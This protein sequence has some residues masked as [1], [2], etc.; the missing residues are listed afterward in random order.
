MTMPSIDTCKAYTQHSAS[1]DEISCIR[2][3]S[4]RHGISAC[5]STRRVK[6]LAV[7]A[8]I[9]PHST[10]LTSHA[11]DPVR[12]LAWS[13]ARKKNLALLMLRSTNWKFASVLLCCSVTNLLLRLLIENSIWFSRDALKKDKT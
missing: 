9:M 3:A 8:W 2:A 7:P 6:L 13:D 11:L 10:C 5:I 4:L 1:S 12:T